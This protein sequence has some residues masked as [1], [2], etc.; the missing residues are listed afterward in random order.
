MTTLSAVDLHHAFEPTAPVLRGVSAQFTAGE[1]VGVVGPSGSGKSTFL[2][3]LGLM[4]TPQQGHVALDGESLSGR[5]DTE[6]ARVRAE[7]YGF[8][9]QDSALDPTRTVLDNI[10]E[11]CLYRRAPRADF[12]A[13]ALELMDR[14][15]VSL[16]AAA[17]PGQVSGGQAQRVALCR[18]L[19]HDPAVVLADEP[20][21]NLD[22]DS[23]T[24]VG[25]ALRAHA[26]RPAVVVVVT[27]DPVMRSFCDREISR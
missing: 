24:V 13:T 16:R 11:G 15:G 4:I 20:T 21:G 9:F 1:V 23:A 6:R 7:R 14:F 2:Y 5:G 26:A 18:A 19:V 12:A 22:P 25:E 27:H 17:R 10:L 3:V 8:V